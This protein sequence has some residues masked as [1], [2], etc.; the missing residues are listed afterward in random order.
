M[1]VMDMNCIDTI[2]FVLT[3]VAIA[4]VIYIGRNAGK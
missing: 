3:I 1:M 2:A 4:F